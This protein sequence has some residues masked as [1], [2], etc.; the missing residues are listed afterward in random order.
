MEE[1]DKLSNDDN[2]QR[3]ELYDELKKLQ[4]KIEA[5][6][7]QVTAAQTEAA[8]RK[9]S[10]AVVPFDGPNQTHRRPIYLECRAEAVVLQPEGIEFSRGRF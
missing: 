3:S 2:R 6:K 4:E 5:A 10:Y 8:L 9:Q 7:K 1:L